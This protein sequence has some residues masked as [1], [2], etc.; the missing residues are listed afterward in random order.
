M[1]NGTQCHP[2]Q[3][4]FYNNSVVKYLLLY[5]SVYTPHQMQMNAV[6]VL[7]VQRNSFCFRAFSTAMR[8]DETCWDGQSRS[9]VHWAH[10]SSVLVQMTYTRGSQ[11]QK[12]SGDDF[13]QSPTSQA[14]QSW[15][16]KLPGVPSF[17]GL[18][19]V[20]FMLLS[21][22]LCIYFRIHKS[23]SQFNIVCQVV[24]CGML[25]LHEVLTCCCFQ[26]IRQWGSLG[27]GVCSL[28]VTSP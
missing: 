23:Q 2:T 3:H 22:A 15:W 13:I 25:H 11:W 20:F 1:L 16:Q 9:Y 12:L 7:E 18:H 10:I 24:C 6:I 8:E 26:S 14:G 19:P 17:T 4:S 21:A 5:N 27:W 28:S